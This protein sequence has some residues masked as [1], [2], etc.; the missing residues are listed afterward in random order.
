MRGIKFRAKR[1]ADPQRREVSR[2]LERLRGK[3]L[4]TEVKADPIRREL[5]RLKKRKRMA[6]QTPAHRERRLKKDHE[7]QERLRRARA[8]AVALQI[9]KEEIVEEEYFEADGEKFCRGVIPL[10][11]RL[12]PKNFCITYKRF[13]GLGY[14]PVPERIRGGNDDDDDTESC[15]SSSR[16]S[17]LAINGSTVM[18]ASGNTCFGIQRLEKTAR[19]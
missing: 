4:R 16:A 13:Y 18:A 2:E 1:N 19:D 8:V 6:D 15:S 11:A 12:Q 17:K 7:N 3:K 10:D 14:Q 5:G 9:A